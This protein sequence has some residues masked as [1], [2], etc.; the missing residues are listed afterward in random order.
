MH[1]RTYTF[2]QARVGA[3]VGSV[4][5]TATYSE[6]VYHPKI[7]SKAYERF[8][9]KFGI[10]LKEYS[11]AEIDERLEHLPKP[12]DKGRLV[13]PLTKEQKEFVTNEQVVTQ[14]NFSYWAERYAWFVHDPAMGG[15][16]GRFEP[17]ESQRVAMAKV[18]ALQLEQW[19][20][21]ERGETT[22]GIR[23][24]EHKGRQQGFTEKDCLYIMHRI[25]RRQLQRG[26]AASVDDDKIQELYDR[27][28][29][30]Y[31]NLPWFLKPGIKYDTKAQDWQLEDTGGQILYQTATQ[32]GGIG[33]GRQRDIGQFT[34]M[35]AWDQAAG[36]DT[37]RVQFEL[38]FVPTLPQSKWTLFFTES[39]SMT[40]GDWWHGFTDRVRRKRVPGWTYLFVPYY[41]QEHKY[42]RTPPA[43]W[44]PSELTK[45][46]IR[47]VWDTS[48]EFLGRHV[49][50]TKPQAYWYETEYEAAREARALNLF[51]TNRCATPEESFQHATRS[52][53]EPELLDALRKATTQPGMYEVALEGVGL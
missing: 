37:T 9:A 24:V 3:Y 43:D 53:F 41:A 23:L 16:M 25:T 4:N 48:Q 32:K 17:W 19:E 29:T 42:T 27:H 52:A 46:H 2:T 14:F 45:R 6:N 13:H 18:A 40:R 15:G 34:E 26:I 11:V 5:T 8:E 7:I 10:R 47:R 33:Q 20:R 21:A 28:K 35:S 39:T 22:D 49:M 51:L 12:N 44:Q 36:W 30:I 31:D 50:L 1:L 38:Q